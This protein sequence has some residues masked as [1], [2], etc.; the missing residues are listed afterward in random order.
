MSPPQIDI[1]ILRSLAAERD[2][3]R[4]FEMA[5][6][7]AARLV[8]ADGAALIE[9]IDASHLQYRFFQGLPAAYRE[10]AS[11]YVFDA[12]AGTAGAALRSGAPVFTADY[13]HSRDALPAFIDSGLRANLVVPLGPA[14][15]RRG[16]LAI[17]WFSRRPRRAPSAARLSIILL[18]ADLMYGALYRQSL[19]Q[20]L[21]QQARHDAL[22]G[23]PNRRYLLSHLER[24][25][26]QARRHP[27][28]LAV[29]VLDLDGFKPVNDQHGHASGDLVLRQLAARKQAALRG[30]DF[31]ARL[32]GDEFALVLDAIPDATE[33]TLVLD[34]LD[35]SLRQPYVLAD[36]LR[37]DCPASIGA[38]LFPSDAGDAE[39][40]LR[41][42]D[43]AMY[44]VKHRGGGGGWVLFR[45]G[46]I[47]P[48]VPVQGRAAPPACARGA[49]Q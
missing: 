8:R 36:G 11:G 25:Q 30:G 32:G 14:E 42:A 33:L 9:C 24:A 1:G 3:N 49:R 47:D 28:G 21:A 13:V 16:V 44:E 27:Q 40:L 22:T 26:A 12:D 5:A 19:E 15:D 34:R 17:S 29:A 43:M 41:H 39:T 38:T 45:A 2:F 7:E 37:V 35:A 18:L 48:A 46:R 10:L 4:F 20:S 23:L 31:I 6:A